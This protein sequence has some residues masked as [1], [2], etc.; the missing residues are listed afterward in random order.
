MTIEN[1]INRL[2]MLHFE[3]DDWNYG[4]LTEDC[5]LNMEALRTAI[6][7][8]RKCQTISTIVENAKKDPTRDE[9]AEYYLDKIEEV[10]RW[11]PI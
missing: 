10:I 3:Q 5:L 6:V 7:A 11:K 1:I 9:Y 2:E 8:L 4:K